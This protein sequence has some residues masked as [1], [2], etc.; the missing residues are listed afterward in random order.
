[1]KRLTLAASIWL[2]TLGIS[3]QPEDVTKKYLENPDF[4]ARF[5][6][7][8][9]P[10]KFT[11]NIA[12]TFEG[13]NERVWMEKWV[14]RGSKLGTNAGMYQTLH[15]LPSGT[16]TLVA[17]AKNINQVNT[18]QVCTGAYLYA[19][20]EQ[21]A[22]NAP[23]NYSVTFTVANG[24][25]D[26]GIRLKDCTGNWVCID[27]LHLYYN[28]VNADSLSTEQARVEAER[29][30]L[31]DK[32]EHANPTSLKVSTFEFIPTGNT[33]ALGRSTI[34][35]TCKEKGFCWSTTPQ[36]T[37]FDESTTETFEGTSIYVMRGLMPA[38]P[39]YIRAY[40]MTSGGYVAYGEER[41][42]VTLPA[43]IMTWSYDDAAIK[44]TLFTEQQAIDVNA[45]IKSASAECVWMYNQLSY[46]PGFHL[47]VHY[48]RGA[49]AGDGT[50]DCSYGGWMRVSQHTAY[51]QTG[52]MLHETNHG[53]GVGTTWEW[54]NNAILRSNVSRGKWLGPIATKM[55]RFINNNNTSLMDGDKSHMWPYGING[56]NEDT[57][58]PS[59]VS[60]YFYNILITHALH[61]DG[62]PCTSSVGFASPAYLFEQRDTI[63]YYL[64]NS[65]FTDGYLYG[66]KLTV[67]YQ[68][69]TTDEVLANDG[70]AWY[71]RYDANKRYYYFQNV[72]TG[73]MLTYN[74]G[75]KVTTTAAPTSA[76]LFHLLPAR[77]DS[78]LGSDDTPLIK[79]AYWLL[80][81]NKYSSPA[82]TATAKSVVESKYDT[83]NEAT[84]QQWFILTADELESMATS[85]DEVQASTQPTLPAASTATYDLLGRKVGATSPS[86]GIFIINGR[87]VVK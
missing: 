47:S 12:N 10:G 61:Q 70:Y 80:H 52:T 43:G 56:A 37:I 19:G 50:A 68:E 26:V 25:A 40:A 81:P 65:Q 66:S 22:I 32:V 45:R 44:D 15:R 33:I 79:T 29:Q 74:S 42:I 38:T 63:K 18:S 27:N 64:K 85:I 53:V 24:K 5:A 2:C 48:N 7:W 30:A 58:Q 87:K 13:K 57:Y 59:N 76:E 39:Y 41:K 17:A 1:M 83:S 36:P 73:K 82:L 3:A 62:L 55:V 71:V 46:I 14:S 67:K 77:I 4:E 31:R 21:T 49:G 78:Q 16:Y 86:H 75:F 72:A 23:G 35:G 84:S 11:Y 9:N 28:G 8:V 20:Q 69:A 6:A 54:T 34:S 51:Q 60:L